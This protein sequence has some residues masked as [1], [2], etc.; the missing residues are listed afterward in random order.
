MVRSTHTTLWG[1]IGAVVLFLIGALGADTVYGQTADTTASQNPPERKI[2]EQYSLF[3][4]YW[5][6]DEFEAAAPY[7]RWLRENAPGYRG[8]R[9]MRRGV[10]MYES[11]AEQADSPERRKAYLDS[12]LTLL[13]EAVPTLRE[14]NVEVDSVRWVFHR[15][16]FLQTY[17]DV[18]PDRQDEVLDAYLTTFEQ[19]PD[20]LAPYYVKYIVRRFTQEGRRQGALDFMDR[21][22]ETYDDPQLMS[23]FDQQR[24]SLFTDPAE[25]AE[26]LERQLTEHP[27][28]LALLRDLFRI[29]Q[30]LNRSD[31]MEQLGQKLLQ[32]DP[33]VEVYR[34]MAE[35]K[36]NQGQIDRALDYYRQASEIAE[37]STERRDLYHE[38]A[39][40]LL[41]NGR[42]QEA[43]RYARRVLEID[44]NYGPAYMTIG[45]VY[46]SAVQRASGQLDR[47]DRAVYWLVIDYYQRAMQ[48]DPSLSTQAERAIDTY[49]EYTP[50]RQD[51]FF[52]DWELGQ[53]LTIDY[54]PYGWIDET[55][56]VRAPSSGETASQ[57]TSDE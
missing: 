42:L 36:E 18:Y 54:E 15:G 39:Q 1:G 31:R 27:D 2:L 53:E 55:T 51:I 4:E 6:N 17:A 14:E 56:T 57:S 32:R 35:L 21:A 13:E 9:N 30:D 52:Q 40:M 19:D 29:Y 26:F 43:R 49:R 3:Y 12:A 47:M 25:R 16:R 8:A 33:T 45:D 44:S 50:A 41:E 5:R 22:E 37:T 46:A 10:E 48:V 38:I 7:F 23:W 20:R 34:L 24:D 11:L 28:S